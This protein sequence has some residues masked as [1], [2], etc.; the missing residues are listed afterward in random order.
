[1]AKETKKKEQTAMSKAITDRI[2]SLMDERGISAIKLAELMG[3]AIPTVY[4][5][6]K[7]NPTLEVIERIASILGVETWDLLPIEADYVPYSKR[8]E[9]MFAGVKSS[10]EQVIIC[11]RCGQRFQLLK[12]KE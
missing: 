11:P 9:G 8:K 1:M 4:F 3:V 6:L 5:H 7:N 10:E 12:D 2:R